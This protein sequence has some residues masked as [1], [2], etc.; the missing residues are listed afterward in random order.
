M[1]QTGFP[2][3]GR[4]PFWPTPWN[5]WDSFGFHWDSFLR[6]AAHSLPGLR[7]Q[8]RW[9]WSTPPGASGTTG[10]EANGGMAPM[11][12]NGFQRKRF[13]HVFWVFAFLFFFCWGGVSLGHEHGRSPNTRAT[14]FQSMVNGSAMCG[15]GLG[16]KHGRSTESPIR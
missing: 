6:G 7:R 2:Q 14:Y 13:S 15:F 10:P 16:H 1:T 8:E 9:A 4:H 3:K 12:A 11:G 5:S